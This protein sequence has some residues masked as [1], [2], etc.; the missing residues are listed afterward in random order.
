M[1]R[2]AHDTAQGVLGWWLVIFTKEGTLEVVLELVVVVGGL[3]G[4]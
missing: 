2:A 3:L 4:Q 1:D